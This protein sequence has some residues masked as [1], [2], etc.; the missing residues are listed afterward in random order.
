MGKR[1]MAPVQYDPGKKFE[2]L[3]DPNV[4]VDFIDISD[5]SI[6][7]PHISVNQSI[8]QLEYNDEVTREDGTNIAKPDSLDEAEASVD[9]DKVLVDKSVDQFEP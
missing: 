1:M 3:V 7:S 2:K 4:P 5:T 6:E 9:S 8:G